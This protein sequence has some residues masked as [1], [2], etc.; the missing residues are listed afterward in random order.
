LKSHLAEA[1]YW[2]KVT[3]FS[4]VTESELRLTSSGCG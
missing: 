1:E 3:T 4:A 2:L